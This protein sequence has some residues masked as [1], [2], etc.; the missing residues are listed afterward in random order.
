MNHEEIVLQTHPLAEA[1][2]LEPIYQHGQDSAACPAE[3]VI[4]DRPGD[5]E[6]GQGPTED[7]AWEDAA[8]RIAGQGQ[9]AA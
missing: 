9:E 4:L 7:A 3:W 1:I 2:A 8:R 6:L 5:Q